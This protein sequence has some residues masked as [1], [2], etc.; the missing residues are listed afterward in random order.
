[1]NYFDGIRP[2]YEDGQTKLKNIMREA[3]ASNKNLKEMNTKPWTN[4]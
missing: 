4:M 3:E 1:M 2:S